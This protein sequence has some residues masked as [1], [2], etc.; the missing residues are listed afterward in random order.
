[1]LFRSQVAYVT[2][3]GVPQMFGSLGP[4]AGVWGAIS[5]VSTPGISVRSDGMVVLAL[6]DSANR[7]WVV[8]KSSA[9]QQ[10]IPLSPFAT[11][12]IALLR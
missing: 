11:P 5:A 4:L 12:A 3:A 9:V 8:N 2:S 1:M 7:L 6:R 10:S